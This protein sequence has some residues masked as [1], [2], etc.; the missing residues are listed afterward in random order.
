MELREPR[1]KV[2]ERTYFQDMITL[3][4]PRMLLVLVCLVVIGHF[5]SEG[6]IKWDIF[7]YSMGGTVFT[8]LAAYR[9]N[10]YH[11]GTSSKRIPRRHHITTGI[12]LL[13]FTF[14][15]GVLLM[16]RVGFWV[17]IPAFVAC[18]IVVLYNLDVHP[19]IHNRIVYGFIWGMVPVVYSN[20]LQTGDVIS[21][22][23]VW[24]FGS[25]AGV[26][27]VHILWSWGPMTCGRF[28]ICRRADGYPDLTRLC[29]SPSIA[30]RDRLRMPK[31]LHN[32]SK[33]MVL[34]YDILVFLM[35]IFV[36]VDHLF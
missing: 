11:D 13:F 9:F 1:M 27:A 34:L 4:H 16:V 36:V 14:Q 17:I 25:V 18:L 23:E 7:A 33:R 35:T 10:E 12:V 31:E 3:L 20:M 32:H 6:T 19:L 26:M 24:V 15:C 30:C 29:H 22:P 8:I 2:P 5:L 28:E 21:R